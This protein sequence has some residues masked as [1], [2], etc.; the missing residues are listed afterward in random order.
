MAWYVIIHSFVALAHIYYR[1]RKL[2]G[3]KHSLDRGL[4]EINTE[5]KTSYT[6]TL[7]HAI[8]PVTV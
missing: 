1:I 8:Q 3:H 7:P 4:S 2:A 6:V 5:A